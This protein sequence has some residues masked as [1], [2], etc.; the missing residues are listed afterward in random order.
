MTDNDKKNTNADE[1]NPRY[2]HACPRC[3]FLGHNGAFDIY[4]CKDHRGYTY[5]LARDNNDPLPIVFVAQWEQQCTAYPREEIPGPCGV[6]YGRYSHEEAMR[7]WDARQTESDKA[8]STFTMQPK[9]LD[10]ALKALG[11]DSIDDQ[12][13]L[14]ERDRNAIWLTAEENREFCSGQMLEFDNGATYELTPRVW[15]I[16]EAAYTI[17]VWSSRAT[18]AHVRDTITESTTHWR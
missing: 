3:V 12:S 17:F 16:L 13:F 15:S 8:K 10:A 6:N 9:V 11:L 1:S 2:P 5:S 7:R 18:T 14:S 4:A